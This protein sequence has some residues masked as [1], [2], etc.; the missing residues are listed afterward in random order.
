[1]NKPN[2]ICL[3]LIQI[4]QLAAVVQN[5]SDGKISWKDVEAEFPKFSQQQTVDKKAGDG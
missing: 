4:T 2:I 3:L 5:L 1:M